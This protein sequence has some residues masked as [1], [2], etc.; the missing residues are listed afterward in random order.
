MKLT[1]KETEVMTVLWKS[2]TPLTTSEI[3]EISPNR[4]WHEGSIFVIMQ[5]LLKK[6]AITLE[7]YRPTGGKHARV[8]KP[9]IT[10]EDYAMRF[11]EDLDKKGIDIDA[12]ILA[13]RLTK[14]KEGKRNGD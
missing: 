7:S 2:K 5:R 14:S 6:G 1:G 11:I 3:I 10:T 12:L 8:Y 9:I 4:T 13:E